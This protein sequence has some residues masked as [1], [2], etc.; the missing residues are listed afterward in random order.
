MCVLALAPWGGSAAAAEGRIG[1]PSIIV[2]PTML[3]RAT[4]GYTYV[5]NFTQQGGLPPISWS[6]GGTL[7]AGLT[8]NPTSGQ[9]LGAPTQ[10]GSF[11]ISVTATDANA[12]TGSRAYTLLV[13]AGPFVPVALAVDEAGNRVFEPGEAVVVAPSWRNDTGT[14][15]ALTG[16]AHDFH[17][18]GF[19]IVDIDGDYGT[20][21]AGATAACST[22]TGDCYTFSVAPANPRPVLHWDG[23]FAESLSNTDARNWL[24]HLGASFSDVPRA[25]GFYRF[26]E[27]LLHRSV[28]GGCGADLYCPS[29]P[30]AREQMAVFV[31]VAREGS[32]YQPPACTTPVF[33]DVPASSPF[34]RWIEELLR[35]GVVHGC[36]SGIFCPS[37]PVTREQMSVFVL[38]TLDPAL[39]PP[40][41]TTPM[42]AD[43]P[44]GSPFCKWIEELVRRGVVTGCGGGNYCPTS[45]VTREQMAV[46]I[47]V[48]FGL[49]LYGP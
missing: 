7:P 2:L 14:P 38:R 11:P 47:S 16:N 5:V 28:T 45:P 49:T 31:L 3:S 34:C 13:R 12:C 17:G 46:F 27:T 4:M 22:A 43:V 20:V 24:L 21:G 9:L 23:A 10:W 37:D 44:A 30:T 48:T 36:G 18:P 26:V 1:C 6:Q 42:F 39:N 29:A 25:S 8:L 15:E 35:R 32:G 19:A 41:C 33:A 40:A